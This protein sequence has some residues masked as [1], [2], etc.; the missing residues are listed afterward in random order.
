[1]R[2]A[3]RFLGAAAL[4]VLAAATARAEPS[5]VAPWVHDAVASG[6]DTARTLRAWFWPAAADLGQPIRVFVVAQPPGGSAWARTA[7]GWVDLARAALS[8]LGAATTA[9][10]SHG[11][12]IVRDLDVRGLA[13]TRV[14][15]GYGVDRGGDSAREDMLAHGKYRLVAQLA[16]SA[17]PLPQGAAALP[18]CPADLAQPRFG[19]PPVAL[20]DFIAMRP[21]GFQTVPSHVLPAKH[22]A[23][24]MTPLGAAPQA[25]PVVAPAAATVTEVVEVS[26]AGGARGWQVFMHPCRELRLYFGHLSSL[27]PRLAAALGTPSRCSSNG[28]GTRPST[29]WYERLA[30]EVAEGE[31]FGS[32]PDS[33]GVDFGVLDFRRAP[34]AFAIPAHYDAFYPYYA[35]PLEYFT[36]ALAAQLAAKTG[37]VLGGR[38][39]TAAPVGGSY[40][41]DLAGTAQGNWFVPGQY[42]SSGADTASF[43]ALA[44]DYVDPAQPL[45]ALGG[46]LPGLP[47]GLYGYAVRDSGRVNR[48]PAAMRADGTVHCL[49]GFAGGRSAGEMP[50]G[51]ASGV[52][53]VQLANEAGLWLEYREVPDCSAA[54]AFGSGARL[55]VR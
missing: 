33:A 15:L 29:C 2:S 31:A 23:F 10:A 22:G 9:V 27:A 34:A 45:V 17:A 8:P 3:W 36:P 1:M 7:D 51:R 53:L 43:V 46:G 44:H 14:W 35:A 25:R 19:M 41:Q 5:P 40:A 13:G 20:G 52:L 47:A 12:E 37:S 11:V 6:P 50:L 24:S 55:F 49:Q 30:V 54:T 32:G 18:A 16:K 28:G 26:G 21:L 38:V 48:D 42:W 4:A 39:R